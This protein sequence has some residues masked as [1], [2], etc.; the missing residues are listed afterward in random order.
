MKDLSKASRYVVCPVFQS[1]VWGNP[2][3]TAMLHGKGTQDNQQRSFQLLPKCRK[4]SELLLKPDQL[5]F[6]RKMR[7]QRS[8]SSGLIF[9]F[10][11]CM[12][13]N[14]TAPGESRQI[15]QRGVYGITAFFSIF[16]S[17]SRRRFL[18]KFRVLDYHHFIPPCCCGVELD[19]CSHFFGCTPKNKSHLIFGSINLIL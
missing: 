11:C 18:K 7:F 3:G 12:L 14:R 9:C 1:L 13:F 10:I 4:R 8:S 17:P 19:I 15:K 16:A 6:R 5:C 2:K